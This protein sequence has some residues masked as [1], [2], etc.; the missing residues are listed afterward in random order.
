MSP[1]ALPSPNKPL[2]PVL[3]PGINSQGYLA[4]HSLPKTPHSSLVVY[5]I[6]PSRTSYSEGKFRKY[7]LPLLTPQGTVRIDKT[8]SEVAKMKYLCRAIKWLATQ[9]PPIHLFGLFGLPAQLFL[10]FLSVCTLE[11]RP[12]RGVSVCLYYYRS[13]K[14][15]TYQFGESI[16]LLY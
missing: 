8:P 3:L 12:V 10:L 13:V 9:S 7:F 1:L 15:P 11:E 14:K 2:T 5:P 6:T 4:C 16:A